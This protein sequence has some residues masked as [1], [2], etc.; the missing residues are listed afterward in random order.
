MGLDWKQIR[1]WA[2]VAACGILLYWGLEHLHTIGSGIGYFL[3]II[4]P[5]IVGAAI[6]FILRRPLARIEALFVW[7]GSHKGLGFFKK[8]SR[9]LGILCTF[10]LFIAAVV[11][12]MFLVIPEFIHALGIL[13]SSI[14]QFVRTLQN[15]S[16]EWEFLSQEAIDW[17]GGL[18]IDWAK[19]SNDLKDWVINGAGTILGSTVGAVSA[20]VSGVVNGFMSVVFCIYLL[21]QK[22]NLGRQCTKLLYAIL[23]KEIAARLLEIT[24][25]AGD[26][27]SNFFTG[28]ITEAVILGSMFFVTMTIC[29]FPYAL[30]ISVLIA[31]LAL[32][33][34][35]GA[36][37][38]ALIGTF[39]ILV[40]NPLQA[41]WFVVVFVL[42]QQIEGNLIYPKVVGG[43][44]GLPSIWVLVAV[45]IGGSA[46]GIV[47]M[48]LF[49]PLFSVFYNLL[50]QWT[51]RRLEEK[52]L[53][54]TKAAPRTEGKQ[55]D[56]TDGKEVSPVGQNGQ[57][58]GAAA[59]SQKGYT[60]KAGTIT[61][62]KG[63]KNA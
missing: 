61:R 4:A 11:L 32:I 47:G 55:S 36:F 25:M 57:T 62:T 35:F 34:I 5:F 56:Q 54:A 63:G 39:L 2:A 9:M 60:K 50:R 27:F 18:E 3:G 58:G 48:I 8:T 42:L 23:P 33:P 43:S 46:M 41:M 53:T 28:Q 22:E 37:C 6:A 19:M 15:E 51:N 10:L 17:I 1:Q 12:V 13:A 49:I 38:G 44:V 52:K 31:V 26:T 7:L 59:K 45:T 29:R 30:V 21:A 40:L 16:G 20:V 14:E 24:R